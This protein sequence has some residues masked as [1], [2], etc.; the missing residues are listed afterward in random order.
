MDHA[1]IDHT[2]LTGISSGSVATDA[3]WD[4]AGDLAVGTGADTAAKLTK[5]AAG[6]VPMAG[7]STLAYAFPP[8]HEFDYAQTTSI[9]PI[10]ATTLGTV[11]TVITGNA[12]AYDGSTPVMVE[13]FCPDAQTPAGAGQYMV[14]YLFDGASD[15]GMIAF[16][17]SGNAVN[18]NPIIGK[19]RITPSASTHTY[20]IKAYVS[21]GS[22]YFNCGAAGSD[23][24]VPGFLR[25][26]KV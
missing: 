5:G 10:T 18:R 26:T 21:A 3:I 16:L 17:Y 7:A 2:G 12:V 22:G 15:I 6:T 8:G 25:I 1:D 9:V 4:A 11:D 19:F 23:T 20:S 14:M 24:R 13:F